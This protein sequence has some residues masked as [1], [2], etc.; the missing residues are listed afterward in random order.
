MENGRG[1]D[2]FYKFPCDLNAT[3]NECRTPLYLAAAN[4]HATV[5][6]YLTEANFALR[7]VFNNLQI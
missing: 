5:V 6:Q 1:A 7:I 2:S 4:G 3:D